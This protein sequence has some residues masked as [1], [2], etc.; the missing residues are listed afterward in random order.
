MNEKHGKVGLGRANGTFGEFLQGRFNQSKRS[1]IIT[2][3]IQLYSYAKYIPSE[4]FHDVFVMP[5]RKTKAYRLTKLLKEKFAIQE[6][7]ILV[8]KS[9]IPEGKGLASS[10]ADLVAAARAFLNAYQ[11][12]ISDAELGLLLSRIEPTDGVM[13]NEIVAFCSQE[14]TCI[15]HLGQLPKFYLIGIDE[16]GTV[17]TL[18]YN[19]Y[20][21]KYLH[22]E[23]IDFNRL[24]E[25]MITAFKSKDI[26]AIGNLATKSAE[27]NQRILIKQDLNT[28]IDIK[29][30]YSLPGV[31]IAHS[32]TYSGLILD[33]SSFNN[34]QM[35]A[36]IL[37]EL[38]EK[39]IAYT[40]FESI[41]E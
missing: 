31:V 16:G 28:L 29:D 15:E 12:T 4:D 23:E 18:E 27:I 35:V 19:K 8:I 38:N 14:G 13:Y 41:G 24:L 30:R 25:E 3:P 11:L 5:T 36:K 34:Q 22:D 6:G 32:G 40:L 21:D 26:Y 20:V 2:L 1:F 17:D 37:Q 7:G 33:E 10:S 39:Q 9:E